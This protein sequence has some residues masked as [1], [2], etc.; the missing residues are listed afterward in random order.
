MPWPA[1]APTRGCNPLLQSASHRQTEPHIRKDGL[2]QTVAPTSLVR[3]SHTAWEICQ[4]CATPADSPY[5]QVAADGQHWTYNDFQAWYDTQADRRWHLA[6]CAATARRAQSSDA[7]SAAAQAADE[8]RLLPQLETEHAVV[9]WRPLP[10]LEPTGP[11]HHGNATEHPSNAASAASQ[12]TGTASEH[13]HILLHP[14]DLPTLKAQESSLV[15]RRSLHNLARDALNAITAAGPQGELEIHLENWF[16][17]REYLA[18]HAQ[19]SE[20]VGSGITRATAEFTRGTNDANRGDQAR[21]D[22]VVDRSDGTCCRFHPGTT[23]R[24]DAKLIFHPNA[25]EHGINAN[26]ST[27]SQGTA[28]PHLPFTYASAMAVPQQDRVG[29]RDAFRLLKNTPCGT[30]DWQWWLFVSNVGSLTRELIGP[31]IVQAELHDKWDTGVELLFRR[32]DATEARL[33]LT[34]CRSGTYQTQLL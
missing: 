5:S 22:F 1:A 6:A 16:P 9:P 34:E 28:Q 7:A 12:S 27:Q 23:K 20:I 26:T 11:Q 2:P 18:F 33:Q 4:S 21:M 24:T 14:R 15:P 10:G 29:K 30:L 19:A 31:G 13:P 8:V 3:L 32:A 17:W 25:T